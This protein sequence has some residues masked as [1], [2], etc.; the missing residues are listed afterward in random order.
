MQVEVKELVELRHQ[1]AEYDEAYEKAV[2][3]LKLKRD[4]LQAKITEKLKEMGV[5]SQRFQEATVTMAVRK[6]VQVL[7]EAK[8]VAAL[9][10][11]G[12][13]DYV[14]ET[15]N[16]L[17]WDSAAKQIAKEGKTDID[18]LVVQEKEYLSIRESDKEERRKVTTD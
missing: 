2:A 4:A 17:F 12:L 14:S 5:L 11:K 9:K 3:P 13:T 7:D 6:S 10:E 8:A 1:I 18:G 16:K 15:I